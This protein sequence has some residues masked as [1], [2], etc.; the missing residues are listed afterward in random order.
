MAI[1]LLPEEIT[2]GA[3]LKIPLNT[4]KILNMSQRDQ[5]VKLETARCVLYVPRGSSVKV[6]SH[7]M[8]EN[9]DAE[10]KNPDSE[11]YFDLLDI[12][13]NGMKNMQNLPKVAGN[14][15][16]TGLLKHGIEVSNQP[17]VYLAIKKGQTAGQWDGLV[18]DL[19][20]YLMGLHF[21]CVNDNGILRMI[22][23]GIKNQ[24]EFVDINLKNG[25]V[26]YLWVDTERHQK[27]SEHVNMN[28]LI[29]ER[30]NQNHH[31]MEM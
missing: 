19:Q 4:L 24:L 27:V 7:A 20:K 5:E 13:A 12:S 9:P 30:E 23:E 26:D 17:Q 22:F 18:K 15:S 21:A 14:N 29:K 2:N 11:G 8:D 28:Q 1:S 31:S 16:P 10:D 3:V 6:H 25:D